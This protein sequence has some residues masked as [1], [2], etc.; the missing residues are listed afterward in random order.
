[1]RMRPLRRLCRA[2]LVVS[3]AAASQGSRPSEPDD[4]SPPVDVDPFFR[5][6]K[7]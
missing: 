2:R 5:E 1:M 4:L 3:P 7:H 6:R